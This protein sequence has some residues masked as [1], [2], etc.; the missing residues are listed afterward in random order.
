M[1][2]KDPV[3][4]KS[5][6]LKSGPGPRRNTPLSKMF[7]VVFVISLIIVNY[8]VFF[9]DDAA[10]P[11]DQAQ[12]PR[13]VHNK[14]LNPLDRLQKKDDQMP[15]VLPDR[16]QEPVTRVASKLLRGETVIA[17]LRKHKVDATHIL[18]V[19]NAMRQV[20]NFRHAQAGNNY[21]LELDKDRGILKMV[22]KTSPVNI[23]VVA[24]DVKTNT[25]SAI[26]QNVEIEKRLVKLGCKIRKN[27]F[28]SIARCGESPY[29]ANH[30]VE[31]FSWD[32]DLF[33]EVRKGDHFRLIVEKIFIK[34]RFYK[35]GAVIA[36]EYAGKFGS[37]RIYRYTPSKSIV[38][39]FAEDGSSAKRLFTKTPLKYT[40][41][42]ARFTDEFF[43]ITPH[44]WRQHVA[45][46][47]Q[48]PRGTPV[49]AVNGGTVVFSG[50]KS[51]YGNLVALKHDNG[52][53]SYYAFLKRIPR[54]IFS[55]QV[56]PQKQVI[57]YVGLPPRSK[58]PHLHFALKRRKR[59]VRF[60]H[61]RIKPVQ[62]LVDEELKRFKDEIKAV[63]ESLL[64][65][66]VMGA[67]DRKV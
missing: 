50:Q 28:E 54:G 43:T 40:R 66:P 49:W 33:R 48:A 38:G 16:K 36:A 46:D 41:R 52:Y 60:D 44:K 56:V 67:R 8:M 39:Y 62:T 7:T 4:L 45:V 37:R 21:A 22:Y 25:F 19:I 24:R 64:K 27:L 32:F 9:K 59:F 12:K 51:G 18:P 13:K 20:F 11:R 34:G 57:G 6:I 30:L 61:L 55:G 17:S 42:A 2:L 10:P 15:P 35:Y 1:Y 26:K 23:Y 31:L 5:G 58:N 53:T 29:L 47:Y 63:K 65:I 3:Y 14:G